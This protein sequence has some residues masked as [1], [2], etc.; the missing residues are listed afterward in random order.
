MP[1]SESTWTLLVYHVSSNAV[2]L[3]TLSRDTNAD[4]QLCLCIGSKGY[5]VAWSR[6]FA[7]ESDTK[8]HVHADVEFAPGHLIPG[9][10]ASNLS[11]LTIKE[12]S[13][14]CSPQRL[15]VS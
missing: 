13:A 5:A 11:W 10:E 8:Q 2:F 12:Q 3:T 9:S 4:T 15:Q 1:L 7:A 6:M 14:L